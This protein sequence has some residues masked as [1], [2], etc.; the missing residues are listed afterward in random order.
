[1]HRFPVLCG[2]PGWLA[3]RR[4]DRSDLGR[5]GSCAGLPAG[6]R[7]RAGDRRGD[8]LHLRASRCP[9]DRGRRAD[10]RAGCDPARRGVPGRDPDPGRTPVPADP[11][12]AARPAVRG[13]RHRPHQGPHRRRQPVRP[14]RAFASPAEPALLWRHRHA[15]HAA[16]AGVPGTGF[17]RPLPARRTA[18]AWLVHRPVQVGGQHPG[19]L[20]QRVPFAGH[21]SL[22]P[23]PAP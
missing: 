21:A 8:R 14:P 6:V 5:P 13:R 9:Q 3:R 2:E 4:L 10:L 23:D 11:V 20:R 12:G 15:R 19:P 16:A 17:R 1:M 7:R 22:D 18:A